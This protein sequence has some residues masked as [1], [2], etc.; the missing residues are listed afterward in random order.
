MGDDK[1]QLLR[2]LGYTLRCIYPGV[3]AAAATD[4]DD[5]VVYTW[6]S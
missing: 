4:D 2:H 5:D 6:L 1:I 3:K